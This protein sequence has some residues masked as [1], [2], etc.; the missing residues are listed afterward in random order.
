MSFVALIFKLT[1]RKSKGSKIFIKPSEKFID[2]K[3]VI[4]S[5]GQIIVND[6][7]KPS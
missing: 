3:K 1:I 5:K 4:A 6:P 7:T 2:N